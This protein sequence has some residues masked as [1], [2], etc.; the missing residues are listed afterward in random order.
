MSIEHSL[1]IPAQTLVN[2]CHWLV[3]PVNKV[4]NLSVCMAVIVEAKLVAVADNKMLV[5]MVDKL[6]TK[7]QLK[8]V[9]VILSSPLEMSQSVVAPAV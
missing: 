3:M 9:Q 2:D 5:A 8:D 1:A 6:T 7:H 4:V